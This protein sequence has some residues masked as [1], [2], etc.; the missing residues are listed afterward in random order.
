MSSDKILSI[1][2]GEN[3]DERGL[4]E[5]LFDQYRISRKKR[6]LYNEDDYIPQ[7]LIKIYYSSNDRS[8]FTDIVE[9][10]KRKYTN[11]ESRL[12]NVHSK[13]EIEGL[14]L[15][16]DFIRSDD[17][18][19]CPNIYLLLQI[20]RILFSKTPYPEAGGVFR[21]INVYLPGT[22]VSTSNYDMIAS[23]I[24]KLYMEFNDL[25]K[26][27]INLGI[28]NHSENEDNLIKYIN[29]CIV[30]KCKLIKIHPFYDGNGR[31]IRALVNLLFKLA[32]LP[33]I[34]VKL[35]E[36]VP[37]ETAMNKAIIEKDYSLINKFYYYKIC[38]S[39]LE[40]D[41]NERENIENNKKHTKKIN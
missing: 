41:I 35:S 4:I 28:Y 39:I 6:T 8:D 30:L 24:S 32:G 2:A 9:V 1:I 36:R 15:V 16:Y 26:K 11:Q 23:D 40:L 37:Y 34:Y 19:K 25:L 17:W 14:G 22:G 12:E 27:G 38:D 5:L 31:T 21:T 3:F 13:K 7:N 20:H 10:F 33:P 29:E 18:Q